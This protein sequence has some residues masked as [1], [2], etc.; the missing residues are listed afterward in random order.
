MPSDDFE[1]KFNFHPIEDLPPP[2][3]YRHFSKVYP[4]KS[5]KG[6]C[7]VAVMLL[8][9]LQYLHSVI[10]ISSVLSGKFFNEGLFAW[11]KNGQEGDEKTEKRLTSVL[12]VKLVKQKLVT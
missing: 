2:E 11:F 8:N 9:N 5:N 3:D 12:L 10:C 1:A 6:E 7:P 4:S